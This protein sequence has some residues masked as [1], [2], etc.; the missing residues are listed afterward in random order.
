M[1]ERAL[2]LTMEKRQCQSTWCQLAER[3][4]L[5]TTDLLV[6]ALTAGS[7]VLLYGISFLAARLA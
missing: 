4:E 6:L 2:D 7:L 5:S 1:R 3:L